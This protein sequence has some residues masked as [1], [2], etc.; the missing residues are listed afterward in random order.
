MKDILKR[1]LTYN[2][3]ANR[4][5]IESVLSSRPIGE[6]V[7]VIL[8]HVLNAHQIW[9]AR[10][11]GVNLTGDPREVRPADSWAGMNAENLRRSLELVEAE[12]L[13]RVVEYR[14]TKGN[15]HRNRAGDIFLQVLTHSSYHRGQLALLLGQEQKA[16]PATDYIFYLRE[17]GL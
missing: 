16:P 11:G 13:D 14:D 9:N 12:D 3:E 4:R 17:R 5:F 6:R 1:L 8:S 7:G 15:P 2:D 10:V